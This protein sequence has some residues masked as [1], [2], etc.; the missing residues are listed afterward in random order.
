M[1]T[2]RKIYNPLEHDEQKKLILWCDNV[3]V[4]K[5]PKLRLKYEDGKLIF[6]IFAVPN[7]SDRNVIV[8]RKLKMEGVR[9][10]ISD[11]IL[12]VRTKQY[13]G[14]MI[15]MKRRNN[16][17]VSSEQKTWFEFFEHN[18]FKTVVCRGCDEAIKAIEYY[19]SDM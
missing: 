13:A 3:A 18:G 15:E 2:V 10:G 11:L 8:G 9:R 17:V 4:H 6:P 12:L 5:W 19:L 16:G 14:L 7:G 1:R